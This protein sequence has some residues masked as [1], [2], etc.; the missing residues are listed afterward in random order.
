MRKPNETP[1]RAVHDAVI[2]T[3]T[4][5]KIRQ[6]NPLLIGQ[7]LQNQEAAANIYIR[8]GGDGTPR[9]YLEMAPKGGM[10]Q[11]ILPPQGELWAY[12]DTGGAVLTIVDKY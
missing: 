9:S 2:L 3:T 7:I 1:T 5:R 11:D 4:P 8:S 6:Q 10:M 12:S